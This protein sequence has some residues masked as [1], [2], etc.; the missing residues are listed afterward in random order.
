[1]LYE[2]F[3]L[4]SSKLI[5]DKQIDGLKVSPRQRQLSALYILNLL[6][7]TSVGY[8]LGGE[9]HSTSEAINY[10]DIVTRFLINEKRYLGI[11]F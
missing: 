5:K 11:R 10:T 8:E 2:Y 6:F 3:W 7:E 4:T 9:V 1:M